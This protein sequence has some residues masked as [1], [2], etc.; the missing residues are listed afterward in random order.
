MI[1]VKK[2]DFI[3]YLNKKEIGVV[4]EVLQN[5]ANVRAWWHM[6]GTA[7]TISTDS[8]IVV[9]MFT[10]INNTFSNEYAKGSLM[11]RRLR[12]VEQIGDTSDLIDDEDVRKSIKEIITY[13]RN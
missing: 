13:N 7:S 3:V 11:E 2:G 10:V 1:N 8:I 6:G 9:D 12:L 5:W 4:K